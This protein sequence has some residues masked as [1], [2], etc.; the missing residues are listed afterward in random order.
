MA[1][2]LG[3][4]SFKKYL[5]IAS[6][7]NINLAFCGAHGRAKT[8]LVSQYCEENGYEPITIILSRMTPE[9]MIGLPTTGK[10][11][12]KTVTK[13]SSPDWLAK[14]SDGK[15][16]VLLFFDE[17]NNAEDDTQASILDLIESRKANGLTLNDDCQIVMAF[18]PIS[19]APN[20]KILSKATRDRICVLPVLDSKSKDDYREYYKDNGMDIINDI[21][22]NIDGLVSN[23]DD[24]IYADSYKNAEFTYRS[25]EKSYKI[26]KYCVDNNIG[27]DVASFL[28]CGYAG[29]IGDSF[30]QAYYNSMNQVSLTDKIKKLIDK[31][32]ADYVISHAEELGLVHNGE[33]S[34]DDSVVIT[35]VV[36]EILDPIAFDKFLRKMFT[37]E[38][39]S[40]YENL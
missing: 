20:A 31:H 1:S 4:G 17:F 32:G 23:Y 22:D 39:I 37:K 34:F 15:S 29:K 33:A 16:K 10:L 14:A 8:S 36:K 3:I 12:G 13:F 30:T 21:L 7:L 40:R 28:V 11:N 6:K 18:N 19:I 25:L 24:E 27:K 38:F 35:N 26:V 2:N 5:E 9:D